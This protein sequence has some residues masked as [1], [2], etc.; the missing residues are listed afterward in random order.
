MSRVADRIRMDP[1]C[2]Y[3]L[4]AGSGYRSAL[5]SKI[6]SFRGSIWSRGGPWTLKMDAWRLKMEPRIVC[7]PVVADSHH[8]DE[9]QNPDSH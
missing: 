3:S 4:E 8:L 9:E 2:F 1:H 6:R 7:R 5:K